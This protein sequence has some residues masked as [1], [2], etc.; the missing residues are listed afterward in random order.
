[1]KI[2]LDYEIWNCEFLM[3]KRVVEI[4]GGG[5]GVGFYDFVWIFYIRNK[6]I[7]KRKEN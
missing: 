3:V 6:K 2:F 4:G 7:N 1:M 5:G